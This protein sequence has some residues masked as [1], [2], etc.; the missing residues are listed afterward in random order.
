MNIKTK[1]VALLFFV[2]ILGYHCQ[3]DLYLQ[4]KRIFE[5]QCANCHMDDGS[6][7]VEVIHDISNSDLFDSDN[8]KPLLKLLL[9]GGPDDRADGLQMPAYAKTLNRVELCNTI[10]YLN[11]KWDEDF[12]E[13]EIQ[14]FD[15]L[16]KKL[17]GQ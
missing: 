11:N 1:L 6:G 10:N 5:A 14:E 3:L 8:P 12:K 13:I 17:M 4:G 15:K 9:E 7:L 2:S 16:Y